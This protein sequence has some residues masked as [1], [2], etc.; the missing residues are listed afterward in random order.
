M[1][2]NMYACK[3]RTSEI[4]PATAIIRVDFKRGKNLRFFN[5]WENM[6]F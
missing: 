1:H 2:Y 4:F 5:F 6:M 3:D